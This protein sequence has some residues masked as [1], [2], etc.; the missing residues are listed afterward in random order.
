MAEKYKNHMILMIQLWDIRYSKRVNCLLEVIS[1][2]KIKL[3]IYSST[4]I[5]ATQLQI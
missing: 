4:S 3:I 2:G 5:R 1:K